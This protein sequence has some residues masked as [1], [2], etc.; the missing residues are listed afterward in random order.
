MLT[1]HDLDQV[2]EIE[3]NIYEEKISLAVDSLSSEAREVLR[4]HCM[5]HLLRLRFILELLG[6]N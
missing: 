5:E 4:Y 2:V 3:C 6:E 1:D